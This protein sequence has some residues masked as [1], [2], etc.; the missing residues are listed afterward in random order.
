MTRELALNYLEQFIAGN[1]SY[2]DSNFQSAITF[3][4]NNYGGKITKYN[5]IINGC[6]ADRY[7]DLIKAFSY[8]WGLKFASYGYFYD[9]NYIKAILAVES[10]MGTIAGSRYGTTDVM[11]CLDG[12]NPA[13]YCMAKIQPSNSVSYDP[14]EGSAYGLKNGFKAL[15]NIFTNQTKGSPIPSCYNPTLSICF[16]IL[17][18]GFKTARAGNI[19][20]GVYNYN[21]GGDPKY[22]EKVDAILANPQNIF[23]I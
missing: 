12:D 9:N 5:F 8:F 7:D 19:R 22:L 13:I 23:T 3:L 16:G 6:S 4:A 10:K 14:Y 2:A 21:G 18:L 20:T 11:Q 17:W 15:K 1:V